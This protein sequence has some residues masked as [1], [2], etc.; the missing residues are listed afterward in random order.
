MSEQIRRAQVWVNN[1]LLVEVETAELNFESNA[2]RA[3]GQEGVL[4]AGQG[5]P[6]VEIRFSG[7]TIVNKKAGM[8]AIEDAMVAQEDVTA[9][10]R[11]G[12]STYQMSGRVKT[13]SYSSDNRSG[14][15]KH[16]FTIINTE[17]PKKLA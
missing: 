2:E 5:N 1:N 9:V 12:T 13:G 7:A 3:H 10:Y 16:N 17:N 11:Q 15:P 6:E 8:S 14:M 4:G